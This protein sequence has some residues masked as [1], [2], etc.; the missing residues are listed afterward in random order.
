MSNNRGKLLHISTKEYSSATKKATTLLIYTHHMDES[1]N[2]Y[3]ESKE[4]HE[5]ANTVSLYL[6]KIVG[7]AI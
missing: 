7:N 6:Y 2:N 4:T 5:K 3:L 1:Q